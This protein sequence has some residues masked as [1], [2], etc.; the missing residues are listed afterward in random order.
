MF[1]V[2]NAT[3]VHSF[4]ILTF[5][6]ILCNIA[7]NTALTWVGL[8]SLEQFVV[9]HVY[10]KSTGAAVFGQVQPNNYFKIP[11]DGLHL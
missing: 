9:G 10:I 3:I 7:S 4:S 5:S 11:F 2:V 1:T 6:C 8:A